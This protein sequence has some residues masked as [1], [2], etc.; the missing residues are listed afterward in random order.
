MKFKLYVAI[1]AQNKTA[2]IYQRKM[3]KRKIMEDLFLNLT[4]LSIVFK[5]PA[6]LGGCK[7]QV[8]RFFKQ[9]GLFIGHEVLSN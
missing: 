8:Y 2:V 9:F 1:N 6:I 4:F 5:R 3:L 7:I